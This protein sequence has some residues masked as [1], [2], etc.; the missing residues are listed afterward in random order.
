M[1]RFNH[2][3]T[4]QVFLPFFWLYKLETLSCII[5][6]ALI[7]VLRCFLAVCCL[8]TAHLTSFFRSLSNTWSEVC[9]ITTITIASLCNPS[10]RRRRRRRNF[11]VTV[12]HRILLRT[13]PFS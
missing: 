2:F 4:A 7:Q 13:Q 1:N 8:P 6:I 12:H 9:I 10:Y 3:P 11:S 5:R